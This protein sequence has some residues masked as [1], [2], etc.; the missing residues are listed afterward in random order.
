L[1]RSLLA[2]LILLAG[3]GP[4]EPPE[5]PVPRPTPRPVPADRPPARP[6]AA[7]ERPAAAPFAAG[8]SIRIGI[9]VDVAEARVGGGDAVVVR[10]GGAGQAV[11]IPRGRSATLRA[12][13]SSV[14]LVGVGADRIIMAPLTIEPA[15]QGEFVRV[16]GK[17]YR[18][19]VEVR[20]SAGGL[21]VIDQLSFEEY[22]GGVV[23]AEL[24]V[25]DDQSFEA[26]KAQA[27]IARTYAVKNLGRNRRLGFDLLA[28]VSDQRY[29]GVAG[30]TPVAWRAL[31]ETRGEIVSFGG[32]AI[33]AFFHSTCGGRT[34]A[35]TEVFPNA[36]RPYLRS[37]RD[38][39]PSGQAWCRASP[40][41]TWTE[42][43]D[44]AALATALRRGLRLEAA[45]AG[46]VR[47]IEVTE[48]SGTGRATR[49]RVRL[50][51][52]D[53]TVEGS[54]AIRRAL[55]PTDLDLLRSA[56]FTLT[57]RNDGDRI[58]RLELAGQGAGHGVGLCQWGAIGRA[59][60]GQGYPAILTAYY[61]GTRLERRW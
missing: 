20:R 33:D 54:N 38:T 4:P 15:Q 49:L 2:A 47:S 5:V 13:P 37:V 25:S 1:R 32:A 10:P 11:M 52:R 59:R 53:V 14:T 18:G 9:L 50:R 35:G 48:R 31:A 61:P 39:D 19:V 12:T 51:G 29:D 27:V 23:A 6:P 36:D 40:R 57:T 24:G 56:T 16:G 45:E 43:W 34:A 7:P 58:G 60:A 17:D 26:V 30:E 8:P 28:T 41:F 55:P 3:C 44:G 21:V 46:N 42:S 22:L